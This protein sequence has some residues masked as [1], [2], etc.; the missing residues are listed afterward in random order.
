ML[1]SIAAACRDRAEPDLTALVVAE[2]SRLPGSFDGQPLDATQADR[3]AAWRQMLADI[4]AYPWPDQPVVGPAPPEVGQS[5]RNRS[6]IAEVWGG[7]YQGGMAS[8]PLEGGGIVNIFSDDDGPYP[9]RRVPGTDRIEYVGQGRV[10]DQT[11]KA[12][13]NA[14]MERAR[15]AGEAA[16][17]WHKPSGGEFTFERWIVIVGRH[18]EWQKTTDGAWRRVYVYDL[19]PVGSPR[20]EDWPTSVHNE[21]EGRSVDDVL[22]PTPPDPQA[23]GAPGESELYRR[24]ASRAATGAGRAA[25]TRTAADYARSAAARDAVLLRAHNRCE[26]PRCAG[27]PCDVRADGASILDVDHVRDLAGGGPDEPWNMIALCPNC[28]AAKTRGR[29]RE[30]LRTTFSKVARRAHDQALKGKP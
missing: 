27:M 14:L 21:V 11:L 17:Y 23:V 7:D 5:F 4:R 3:V 12:R 19:A 18:R 16:R 28:H 22:A 20:P 1:N 9:D 2:A 10:G 6:A 15:T 30:R 29:D 8:F 24:L 13:G 25:G 26:N